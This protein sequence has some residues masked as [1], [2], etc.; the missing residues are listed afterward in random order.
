MT[1]R[2][3][4]LLAL[5]GLP[6]ERL[7]ALLGAADRLADGAV[8]PAPHTGRTVATLF[9]EDST[10]TRGSFTAAARRLGAEVLDLSGKHTSVS[11]GET[12]ADTARTVAAFGVD[13]VVTRTAQ[14]GGAR[15]IAGAIG[16]PVINAGDGRHEHPTQGLLDTLAIARAHH[17]SP[18][19]DLT[20][21]HV[22]IVGDIANSR[23]ARSSTAAL[24]ALGARVT[25]IGP[26]PL[27]P[28]GL[29]ALGA[30]VA[31]DLDQ[32]LA[33]ADAVMMLRV[34][35]ERL[36]DAPPP[37]TVRGYRA[38]FALTAERAAH[39]KRDAV[40]LHP[41]PMNR[42]IEIDGAAADGPRSLIAEQVRL[43]VHVR[44][45]VLDAAL[46][47]EPARTGATAGVPALSAAGAV[48]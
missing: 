3:R 34:Q 36:G 31:H 19:F 35:F 27:A 48:R 13:A 28:P 39:M 12:L 40:V 9:F 37:F 43:G 20:G 16:V 10:R 24:T 26:P 44:T 45:A 22:L 4:D 47:A 18:G 30:E 14:S 42:G 8:P 11:K 38:G 33:H 17:R 41:G 23:V 6:V 32:H 5:R 25:L 21:L 46:R 1:D 15:V 7:R 29:R 2:S